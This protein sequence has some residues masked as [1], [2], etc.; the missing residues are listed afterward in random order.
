MKI[1]FSFGFALF[2]V[3][4]LIGAVLCGSAAFSIDSSSFSQIDQPTND[5]WTSAKIIGEKSERGAILRQVDSTYLLNHRYLDQTITA[6]NRGKLDRKVLYFPDVSGVIQPFLV[7]ERSNFS[8]VLAAKFPN[9]RAYSGVG[10]NNTSLKIRFSYSLDGISAVIVGDKQ[11]GKT[12][13]RK[14]YGSSDQYYVFSASQQADVRSVFSC[15]TPE[16]KKPLGL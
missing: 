15:M 9:I 16:P 1:D 8:A 7:K 13:I 3:C 2:R 5:Y 10:L 4:S 6:F 12:F 14:R 11:H